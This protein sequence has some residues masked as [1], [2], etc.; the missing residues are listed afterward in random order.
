MPQTI[1]KTVYSFDE[2]SEEAKERAR[3]WYREASA[4][5]EYWDSVYQDAETIAGLMGIE[6]YR[7]NF[8][9]VGGKIS[10]EPC[11]WFSGFS[12]QGDGACFEGRYSYAKG[13]AAKVKAYAP[14]DEKLHAIAAGLQAVQQANGYRLSATV[15]HSGSYYHSGC[16]DI[17]VMKNGDDYA[18]DEATGEVTRLLRA[19]MDWIYRQLE[20][21]YEYFNSDENVDENIRLNEYAFEEEGSRSRDA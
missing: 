16:T 19:F 14:L 4:Q 10:D 15:T 5:D 8:R 17:D 18:S 9:T 2:L 13:G 1:T 3:D 20:S 7:R 21:E 11:I 6:F 12:S